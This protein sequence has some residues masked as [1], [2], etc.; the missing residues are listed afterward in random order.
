MPPDRRHRPLNVLLVGQSHFGGGLE[1][2]V[3]NLGISLN[4][5]YGCRTVLFSFD[6]ELNP[7]VEDYLKRN[8]VGLVVIQKGPRFSFKTVLRLIRLIRDERIDVIHSHETAPLMYSAVARFG[9]LLFGRFPKLVHTQH[10]FVHL[11]VHPFIGLYDRIFQKLANHL[12]AVSQQVV[13]EYRLMGVSRPRI[14]LVPNG[15]EFPEEMIGAG[16]KMA[17]R[18]DLLDGLTDHSERSFLQREIGSTWIITLGRVHPRKGQDHVIKVWQ[19]LSPQTRTSSVLLI[20]GAETFSGE[21]D[22]LKEILGQGP[23][24]QRVVFFGGTSQP[25]RWLQAADVFV[26]GSEY[27]G[28]PLAPLE[29]CAAGLPLVLSNIQGNRV[30]TGSARFFPFE[31]PEIGAEELEKC[32][33]ERDHDPEQFEARN[34]KRA[35]KVQAEFTIS[36]MARTY[37]DLY[38]TS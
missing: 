3:Q 9:S 22:R 17:H 29:A 32:L 23:D 25:I 35:M 1:K 36:A 16:G 4:R 24:T 34:F 15:V 8:G 5:E 27:E 30:L 33:E 31:N 7:E 21:L 28:M 38:R 37:L 18:K 14:H 10:S 12:T 11:K 2:M 20:V 13:D 6:Q 19:A 26:S